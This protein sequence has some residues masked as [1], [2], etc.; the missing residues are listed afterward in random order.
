[1]IPPFA[2]DLLHARSQLEQIR[3]V[4]I[5]DEDYQDAERIS[6]SP[7]SY[8]AR[9]TCH[10]AIQRLRYAHTFYIY[11]APMFPAKNAANI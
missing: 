1:M 9:K 3:N 10:E 6:S 5:N 4:H 2:R 8:F 11:D 7:L